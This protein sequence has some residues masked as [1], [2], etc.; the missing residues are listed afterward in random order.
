MCILMR[1]SAAKCS[2][3]TGDV[4]EGREVELVFI[5]KTEVH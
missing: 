3:V 4:S 5:V 2:D 1:V